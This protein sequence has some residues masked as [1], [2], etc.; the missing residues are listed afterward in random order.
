MCL[1]EPITALIYLSS[2]LILSFP[3]IPG[4]SKWSVP[5][6]FFDQNSV[7]ISRLT[8]TTC[9]TQ[10]LCLLHFIILTIF[11]EEYKL[12][13]SL[14]CSFHKPSATSSRYFPQMCVNKCSE[15]VLRLVLWL[16]QD[17]IEELCSVIGVVGGEMELEEFSLYCIVE[18]DTFTMPLAREEYI[19]DVT[20]E[21]HKNQQVIMYLYFSNILL[22]YFQILV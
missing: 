4:S 5:F 22:F 14:L 10:L 15:V 16:L 21:L 12:W 1:Q 20:T 18:G 8:R 17:V 13:S 11:G 6:R 9:L 19:L 7:H 3:Y 2:I